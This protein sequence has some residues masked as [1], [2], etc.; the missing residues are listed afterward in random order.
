MGTEPSTSTNLL[1]L[2]PRP[3]GAPRRFLDLNGNP[4]ESKSRSPLRTND[5]N[6]AIWGLPETADDAL[7]Q[8][9]ADEGV[10]DIDNSEPEGGS[11]HGSI[12]ERD[13]D[14]APSG[15]DE[16]A[17]DTGSEEEETQFPV[18]KPRGI[19]SGRSLVLDEDE[20]Q[21]LETGQGEDAV[22]SGASE[23]G[24]DS[25]VN[26]DKERERILSKVWPAV[27]IKKNAQRER[28]LQFCRYYVIC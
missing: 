15:P 7:R 26:V 23:E 24:E 20:S 18:R 16:M 4:V 28:Y 10:I 21:V 22:D 5:I 27:L 13:P 3:F 9:Y 14:T 19:I 1:P 25:E 11:E 8:L 6:G 2:K 12:L 17:E